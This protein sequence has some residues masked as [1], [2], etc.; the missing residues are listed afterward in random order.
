M[1]DE[2][3]WEAVHRMD[4]AVAQAS[5]AAERMENAAQRI[6]FLLEDGYGG[7][8]LRLMLALENIQVAKTDGGLRHE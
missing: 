6:A 4:A 5:S 7:N 3:M 8:G 1:N 2:S